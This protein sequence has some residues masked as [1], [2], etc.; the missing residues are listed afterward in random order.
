[1][2]PLVVIPA[3]GASSRMRGRDKLL[4]RVDGT[5]LLRRQA[6][7]AVASGCDVVVA[8]PKGDVARRDAIGGLEVTTIEV[9]DATE[10]LGA[11][12]RAAALHAMKDAPGRAM[13]ILLPDVP[14]VTASDIKS[15]IERFETAG[16][17]TPTRATDAAGRPGTPLIVPPRLLPRF[18]RLTG[19]EGGRA[20]L[21]A[22][23]VALVQ[24]QGNRAT[25][26]LDTPEDWKTWRREAGSHS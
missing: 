21:K 2:N 4:E 20:I 9:E 6:G 10:G 23:T 15:V 11:T 8:V 17:D 14:G 5:P 12:L 7:T 13:M 1:M 25:R 19:D 26:D 24:L 18:A 22:E 16:G 3:A